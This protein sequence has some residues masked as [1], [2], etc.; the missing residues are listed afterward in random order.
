[1]T[2]LIEN[3]VYFSF[4]SKLRSLEYIIIICK[5]L[6]SVENI[7]NMRY[8]ILLI[9]LTTQKTDTDDQRACTW[10][11]FGVLNGRLKVIFSFLCFSEF[12]EINTKCFHDQIGTL[13]LYSFKEQSTSYSWA[14]FYNTGFKNKHLKYLKPVDF[15]NVLM[16]FLWKQLNKVIIVGIV[17][18][19]TNQL[20]S[21]PKL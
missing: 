4:H 15:F 21:S 8:V 13:F 6:I 14:F 7:H 1:M 16:Q 9:L 19:L 11:C 2:F 18:Y 5:W 17:V 10:D 20:L 12:S 3:C